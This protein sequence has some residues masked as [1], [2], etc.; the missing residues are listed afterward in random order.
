MPLMELDLQWDSRGLG[1]I[2]RALQE[3]SSSL[4][5]RAQVSSASDDS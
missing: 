3:S 2:D 1:N 4:G 5:L